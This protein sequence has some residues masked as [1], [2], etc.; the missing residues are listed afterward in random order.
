MFNLYYSK[1]QLYFRFRRTSTKILS[2]YTCKQV[3]C[4]LKKTFLLQTTIINGLQGLHCTSHLT[5]LNKRVNNRKSGTYCT[6]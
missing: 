3:S 6:L 5:N 1:V 4:S 2:Y